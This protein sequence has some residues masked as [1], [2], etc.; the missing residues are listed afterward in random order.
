MPNT[1]KLFALP[2]I[3][4]RVIFS[5]VSLHKIHRNSLSYHIISNS[6]NNFKVKNGLENE[7]L[8]ISMIHMIKQRL[9]YI[10]LDNCTKNLSS[11]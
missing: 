9:Y 8:E 6:I 3:V 4:V 11:I 5:V 7:Y 2:D 10:K 1:G